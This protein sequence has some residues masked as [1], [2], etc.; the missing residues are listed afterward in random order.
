MEREKKNERVPK[1]DEKKWMKIMDTTQSNYA[2]MIKR[3]SKKQKVS[4][5]VLIYYSIFLIIMKINT[6][7]SSR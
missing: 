6:A 4:N 5:F 1:Y 2:N 3:L 7:G